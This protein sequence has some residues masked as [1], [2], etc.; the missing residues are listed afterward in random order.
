MS[1]QTFKCRDCNIIKSEDD[2]AW[3]NICDDCFEKR[4]DREEKDFDIFAKQNSKCANCGH[5]LYEW[6]VVDEKAICWDCNDRGEPPIT[7]KIKKK[8]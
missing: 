2:L 8:I 7:L 6:K 5:E 3:D 1:E 4:M